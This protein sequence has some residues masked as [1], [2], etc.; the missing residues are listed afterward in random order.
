LAVTAKLR[1]DTFRHLLGLEL[2]FFARHRAAD[3]SSRLVQD[4]G[5]VRDA[6]AAAVADVVPAVAI[7]T[8]GLGYA[9]WL[10]WRLAAATFIGAPLVGWAIGAFGRRLH[11]LSDRSQ[12]RVSDVF[13]R[14]SETLAAIPTVKA[15]GREA[16]E[17]ARFAEANQA[18]RGA[19]WDATVIAALQPAAIAVIQTAAIGG[20]LWVGGHEILAGR[21]AAAD[22]IAFAA[23]IGVGID[24]TLALSQAWGRLQAAGGALD[25]VWALLNADERLPEPVNPVPLGSVD[26]AIEVKDLVFGYDREVLHGVSLRA[27]P[28]E[29]VA[30]VGASG[31]GKSSLASLILRLYDPW[32]GSVSLD[33][34]DLRTIANAELREAIALVPQD[35]VLFAGT[36]AQNVAY[37]RPGASRQEIMDA[38]L[39]ANAHAFI[40]DLKG[41]YDA[42]VGERGNGLSGGQRQRLAIARALLANPR[43]L[44]LDEATS[45]L[46]TEAAALIREALGRLMAG[47]TTIVIAHRLE[48]IQDADRVYV[49]EGGHVVESGAPKA[50]VAAN[51]AF[52]RLLDAAG[53]DGKFG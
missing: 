15:F 11:A 26:G 41:G 32:Q 19:L 23:A 22:L 47:R 35:P 52:R 27:E 24:P 8:Y 30:L 40:Q 9:F 51:G 50:L 25:R 21:L 46:D 2:G 10:N 13:V 49:I 12:A 34:R 20:V 17:A 36:V 7:V 1:E 5:L 16:D 6:L 4:L 43:V 53:H 29:I 37:G 38:C 14:A 42:E 39:A 33:G 28:G 18:H 48:Q 31:G 44:V 3:L 45:A